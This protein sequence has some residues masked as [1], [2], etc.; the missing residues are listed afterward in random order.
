MTGEIMTSTT[1]RRYH[2]P[3]LPSLFARLP[4]LCLDY[5][6]NLLADITIADA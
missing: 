1:S 4:Y 5:D 6:T 3:P 2:L